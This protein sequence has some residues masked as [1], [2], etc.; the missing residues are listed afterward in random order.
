MK[1]LLVFSAF[2]Y[3]VAYRKTFEGY[4]PQC[5]E[6]IDSGLDLLDEEPDF[7]FCFE[8]VIL[9][10]AY[11]Q[12]RP[13]NRSRLREHAQSRRLF[14]CPG[15][16]TM[17]DGNIPSAESCYQNALLGRQWL[18]ENLGVEPGPI[19]WMADIFGH[20]AQSPQI[21]SQLGY[22]LYMFERGQLVSADVTDFAWE[23]VDGS[24]ILAHWE[25]DTYYG[26]NLA[27]P[28][29]D[30]R[31]DDWVVHRVTDHVVR[32]LDDGRM[33]VALSKIGGDFLRPERRHLEFV[34]AWNESERQP[35]I[36]FSHPDAYVQDLRARER[37]PVIR[38][39]LNP[40][41]Q[42]TYSSRIRLKQ[43]NR[44]LENLAYAQEALSVALGVAGRCTVW[45]ALATLQ[46]HDIICGS[47]GEAAWRE[48]L[49]RAETAREQVQSALETCLQ[50]GAEGEHVAVFNPL[51]Y[52]RTE[53][54]DLPDGPALLALDGMAITTAARACR[55]PDFKPVTAAGRTLE[56]G[57]LRADFDELGRLLRLTDL[58]TDT[59]YGDEELGFLHDISLEPDFGDP[60]VLHRGPVNASLLHA[61]PYRDPML[62]PGTDRQNFGLHSLR[63]A[64]AQCFPPP[65][66]DT[67]TAV[68]GV[69]GCIRV[70]RGESEVIEY[71]LNARERLLRIK[72]THRLGSMQRRLRAVIPTGIRGGLIRREIPAG[73]IEQQEGEYPAQNWMDYTDGTRGL[74]LLNRGLPGNNITDGVMLL[75]LFRSVALLEPGVMPDF[76]LDVTQS[77][78]YALAPFRP[79][80]PMYAPSRLGR[81]FNMPFITA[82]AAEAAEPTGLR[83]ELNSSSAEVMALR[84]VQ[85]TG[86][87]E[88]RLHESSGQ[89]CM[90]ELKCSRPLRGA[91]QVTPLGK[92][93]ERLTPVDDSRLA[94]PLKPFEIKTLWLE[95]TGVESG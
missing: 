78:E 95:L 79:R 92:E 22:E 33:P 42:G 62:K 66:I 10:E 47:L 6:I 65:G 43:L 68:D 58:Q 30:S 14:F 31:S 75:T 8:Q 2:H 57:L 88:V 18:S 39:E 36:R 91:L 71:R 80:D 5:L 11:W 4:L 17:P 26:L 27:I 34:R 85:G 61:A 52:A 87:I 32:P 51:P 9:L 13:E 86:M 38:S 60:W 28:W 25:A 73:Y 7:L 20:H 1:T 76:E 93:L 41:L 63:G 3:D 55:V 56:N 82:T 23:G 49:A 70:C 67:D 15:M 84:P 74:C 35:A 83:L 54:V 94:L 69:T 50:G 48:S 72:V 21:Y 19:C 29:I 59:V 12:R 24:T 77:A 90:A 16:W 37:L 40:L 46:F 44:E 45:P 89:A 81:C 53:V 64:D